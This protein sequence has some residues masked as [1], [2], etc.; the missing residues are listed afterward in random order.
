MA[1]EEFTVQVSVT[2]D[3]G[4][5]TWN[6]ATDAETLTRAVTLAADDLFG[7]KGVRRLEVAI[8]SHDLMARRAV[9]RA[10]FRREGRSRAAWLVGADDHVDVDRYARLATD[11][12]QA[13]D[14]FSS[15]MNSVLPTKRMIGHV[16]FRD[17]D[18]QVLLLETSYKSDWELPG[19][20]VEPGE[21]P[22]VGAEREV[23]EELG[24]SV[25]LGSPALVDW[26]PPYLGWSDA[27]EFIWDG[28]VLERSVIEEFIREEREITAIHWVEP[29]QV[30]DHV[31]PLSARR[32]ALLVDGF[33]GFT[34]DGV[35]LG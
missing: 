3:I 31:T 25:R 2:G 33:R 9:Q 28:G 19:G 18:G 30:P 11:S 20:V 16:L 6:G 12:Y 13:A 5:L 4:T 26:M 23:L 14:T 8:P 35:P 22:R 7:E 1:D 29:D 34:E 27:V 17:G 10:G 21:P 32:I 24:L 15:V